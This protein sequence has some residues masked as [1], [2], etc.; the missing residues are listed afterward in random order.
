MFYSVLLTLSSLKSM[1]IPFTANHFYFLMVS[2][3]LQTTLLQNK[4]MVSSF[5]AM[6]IC[7]KLLKT[8]GEKKNKT[9]KKWESRL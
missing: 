2:Y 3:Q 6:K 7:F 9:N 4:T 1:S 8:E 5:P